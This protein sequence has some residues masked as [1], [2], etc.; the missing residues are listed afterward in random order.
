[1]SMD[2]L[3]LRDAVRPLGLPSDIADSAAAQYRQR[4][5]S[6]RHPILAFV[7]MPIVLLPLLWFGFLMTMIGIGAGI[8]ALGFGDGTDGFPTSPAAQAFVVVLFNGVVLIP[9]V[10]STAF[11]CRLAIRSSVGWKWQMLACFVL[12]LVASMALAD[13]SMPTADAKG[14]AMFGLGISVHPHLSQIFQFALPL[15]IGLVAL[16]WQTKSRRGMLAS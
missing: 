5:F 3:G 13:V 9:I 1:M 12:A 14:R 16:T 7:A 11:I 4:N 6:G 15:A 10:L 2:A 8:V